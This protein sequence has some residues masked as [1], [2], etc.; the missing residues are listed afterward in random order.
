MSELIPFCLTT[1]S[2]VTE[3]LMGPWKILIGS[4]TDLNAD[5]GSCSGL[6]L[7][8]WLRLQLLLRSKIQT[9][10]SGRSPLRARDHL[11]QAAHCGA[12]RGESWAKSPFPGILITWPSHLI[13]FWA[14]WSPSKHVVPTLRRIF[15]WSISFHQCICEIVWSSNYKR[16]AWCSTRR[17]PTN[18]SAW[19]G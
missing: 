8:Y 5:S 16:P 12:E 6:N 13:F 11:C 10:N 9:P 1:T 4:C 2:I 17:T 14:I 3:I 7:K 19:K 18:H 15:I